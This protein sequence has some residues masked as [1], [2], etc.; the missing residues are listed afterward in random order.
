MTKAQPSYEQLMAANDRAR[1]IV[2][3]NGVNMTQQIFSQT[4][5]AAN[6]RSTVL[7]IP[8]RMVGLI[9][10]FY[11]EVTGAIVQAAAETLTRTA[12]S[13]SNIFSQIVFNDLSNNVRINTTGWHMHLLAS[14][15]RQMPAFAAYTTDSPVLIGSNMPVSVIPSPVTTTQNFR[16]FYE[17]PIT[18]TDFDLRGGIFASVVNATLNLQLTVNPNFVCASTANPTTAVYISSTV[19]DLGT[20]NN[21]TVKVFQ[22]YIDQIPYGDS[23]PILP[24]MD[25]STAYTIYNSVASGLVVGTDVAIPYGN[26]RQFLS[27]IFIYDNFGS[28]QAVGAAINYI[29]LQA[30]NFT[31]IWQVDPF[32]AALW[33]RNIVG[34]D[35]PAQ[36]ARETY[37]FDSRTKPI[38]TIQYGNQQTIFNFSQVQASTSQLLVGFES[39]AQINQVT[40]AGSLYNT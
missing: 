3:A 2:L 27:T 7:N 31:N 30:A 34:D 33:T 23:G 26:F 37:Y 21:F 15:R 5:A 29:G 18:Y 28:A 36:V 11:V 40:Q 25:M 24:A 19:P 39:F 16:F 9:K 1:Q 13:G 20:I 22:N 10:R 38:D 8:M 32:L 4:I 12:F 17:I 6:V 35:F 14:A